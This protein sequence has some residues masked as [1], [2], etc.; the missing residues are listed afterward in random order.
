MQ[1]VLIFTYEQA[2]LVL[3]QAANALLEDVVADLYHI[4]YLK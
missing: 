2:R 3:E 1:N 4:V